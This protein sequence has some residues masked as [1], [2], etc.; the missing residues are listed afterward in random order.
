MYVTGIRMKKLVM[1]EDGCINICIHVSIPEFFQTREV[2][3]REENM[4]APLDSI[5]VCACNK[6]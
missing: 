4:C 3:R 1:F 5:A 2:A 6:I